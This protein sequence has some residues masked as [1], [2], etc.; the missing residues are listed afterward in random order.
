MVITLLVLLPARRSF[1][2]EKLQPPPRPCRARDSLTDAKLI[3]SFAIPAAF[4]YPAVIDS[5]I[6]ILGKHSARIRPIIN[7][8]ITAWYRLTISL[9]RARDLKIP[10]D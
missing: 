2:W 1:T 5:T 4:R 10:L 3:S 7:D 6:G 8:Y 9:P